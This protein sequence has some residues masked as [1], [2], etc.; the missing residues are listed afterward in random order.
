LLPLL[1]L[2]FIYLDYLPLIADLLWLSSR[3]LD[4][5]GSVA[6]HGHAAFSLPIKPSIPIEPSAPIKL[7]TAYINP[8]MAFIKPRAPSELLMAPIEPSAPL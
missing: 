4:A 3:M 5:M 6:D 8:S 1:L 7:T 2:F